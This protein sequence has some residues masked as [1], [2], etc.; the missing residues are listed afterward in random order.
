MIIING[1]VYDSD[2]LNIGT[3]IVQNNGRV[4]IDGVNVD[5]KKFAGDS[6]EIKIEISDCQID[7]LECDN[8]TITGGRVGKIDADNVTVQNG[9]VNGNIDADCVTVFGNVTG[10]I[11]ADVMTQH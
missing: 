5:M 8:V 4:I 10:K 3:T 1:K 7:R 9:N 11:H 6:K 2:T